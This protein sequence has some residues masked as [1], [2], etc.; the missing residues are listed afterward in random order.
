LSAARR[1]IRRSARCVLARRPPTHRP[2]TPPVA[3]VSWSRITRGSNP[4]PSPPCAAAAGPPLEPR[5]AGRCAAPLASMSALVMTWSLSCLLP[6][7]RAP[8]STSVAE[9]CT[10]DPDAPKEPVP[11]NR[12]KGVHGRCHPTTEQAG[13]S[14]RLRSRA[15]CSHRLGAGDSNVRLVP[16]N[17]TARHCAWRW[18]SV[19]VTGGRCRLLVPWRERERGQGVARPPLLTSPP[20]VT[21]RGNR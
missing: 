20:Q 7:A 6:C 12:A 17:R 1:C 19:V 10:P 14:W 4:A 15:G 3:R 18:C 13:G 21:G 11:G 5:G 8:A 2:Q 16:S 9:L